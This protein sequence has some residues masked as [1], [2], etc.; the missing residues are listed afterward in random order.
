MKKHF[1][2]ILFTVVFL[3]S[4]CDR[5]FEYSPYSAN[6]R[7]SFEATTAYNLQKI[8]AI[9]TETG[10]IVE[11][12]VA[13]ISDS[14]LF[15]NGLVDIIN[16]INEDEEILFVIHGGDMTDNGM[17]KEYEI[18]HNLMN[19]LKKPYLT[20][21]GN[22]DFL[23]NGRQIYDEM[24]GEENYSF[25]FKNCK[26][27]FFRD[28]IWENNYEEPDFFWLKA[29][30]ENSEDCSR[31]FVIAHIPPWSDQF[32]YSTSLIYKTLM[33]TFNVDLSI[34]GHHHDHEYFE[35]YNDSVKYLIIGAPSKGS[36]CKMTIGVDSV[37]VE[38]VNF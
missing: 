17:L 10:G 20:A 25:V 1:V 12:K 5:L 15:Y 33:D 27:I 36:F 37:Y 16:L 18:F 3:L 8:K 9:E 32:S 31:I 26:F 34:H 6:V 29:Q 13:L 21:I 35:Y 30:L 22:H 7:K 24:F 2:F 11:F 14:H 19:K 4:G 28:V 23:A 38:K